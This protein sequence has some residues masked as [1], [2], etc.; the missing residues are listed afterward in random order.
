MQYRKTPIHDRHNY[1]YSVPALRSVIKAAGFSS[2]LVWSEDSFE[3]PVIE[4]ITKLR[5]IGYPLVDIGDNIFA[6]VKKVREV[7]N[8]YP[9]AIYTD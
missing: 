1:E 5:E 6:V 2:S 9:T 8:R 4:D 7:V 3:D